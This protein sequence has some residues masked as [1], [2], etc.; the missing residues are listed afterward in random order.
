MH[1]GQA[2]WRAAMPGAERVVCTYV[3]ASVVYNHKSSSLEIDIQH[4][5]N[6]ELKLAGLA[7]LGKI[8]YLPH[9]ISVGSKWHTL[10]R[11]IS[12]DDNVDGWLTHCISS[13]DCMSHALLINV[14]PM[15]SLKMLSKNGKVFWIVF[16]FS[17][18]VVNDMGNCA[19]HACHSLHPIDWELNTQE[20]AVGRVAVYLWWWLQ[21]IN[22]DGCHF[23]EKTMGVGMT[24]TQ[25]VFCHQH[26]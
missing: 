26:V 5:L 11:I 2:S 6:S 20:R 23:I 4:T 15:Q 8:I 17:L 7:V 10:I 3:F 24:A 21:P 25:P 18:R 13:I 22:F 19:P 14:L 12:Q 16:Q 9:S 1:P